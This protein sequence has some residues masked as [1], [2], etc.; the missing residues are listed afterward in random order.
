LNAGGH[1]P[2]TGLPTFTHVH[3]SCLT[4][5]RS[6]YVQ[7]GEQLTTQEREGKNKYGVW[8]E[9]YNQLLVAGG[10]YDHGDTPAEGVALVATAVTLAPQECT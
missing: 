4:A 5:T 9:G 6:L 8:G 10:G 7:G 2:C 1:D 3:A